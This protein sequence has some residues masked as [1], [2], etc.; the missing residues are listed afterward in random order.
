MNWKLWYG[1]STVLSYLVVGSI[2]KGI[3]NKIRKIKP[4]MHLSRTLSLYM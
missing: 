3:V 2:L 4:I 1:E